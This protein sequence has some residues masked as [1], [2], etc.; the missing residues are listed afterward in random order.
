MALQ[1]TGGNAPY[2]PPTAVMSIVETYRDRGLP[3]PITTDIL[4]RAGVS[5][6]LANRTMQALKMLD[7]VDDE[8][9]PTEQFKGL[10]TA[11]SDEYKERLAEVVRAA[12]APVFTF[13][14]P[15]KDSLDRVPDQFRPY[16]PTGQRRRMVILFLGLCQAAGIIPEGATRAKSDT[17]RASASPRTEAVPR[18]TTA[19][20]QN[21]VKPADHAGKI[22]A[23][24]LPLLHDLPISWTKEERA[25]WMAAF[26]ALL[27]YSIP[28]VERAADP[29]SQ[30]TAPSSAS[31]T[32]D[33]DEGGDDEQS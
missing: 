31:N 18:R 16:E 7:L 10:K 9:N 3:C 26:D 15:D 11:R 24:L 6:G 19:P 4:I 14:D 29:F 32:D 23:P 21:K 1:D 20:K 30:F 13:W 12:Y 33:D 27:S 25:K 5:D 2:A 17:P 22:P 28:V 8:G